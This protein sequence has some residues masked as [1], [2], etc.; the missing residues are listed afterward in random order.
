MALDPSQA[1][2]LT[3]G[4]G[5]GAPSGASTVAALSVYVEPLVA[6][7]RVATLFGQLHDQVT[8]PSI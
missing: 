3:D 8:H 2:S 6:D 7:A 4:S 1:T 5:S